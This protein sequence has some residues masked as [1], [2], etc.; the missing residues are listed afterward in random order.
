MR[1]VSAMKSAGC[2]LKEKVL[3]E[4]SSLS[5]ASTQY[6]LPGKVIG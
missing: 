4:N 3:V 2:Y 6:Y 1:Q 5:N